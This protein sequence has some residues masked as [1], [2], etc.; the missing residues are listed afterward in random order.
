M[1]F[2]FAWAEKKQQDLRVILV[3]ASAAKQSTNSATGK[4]GLPRLPP[5]ARNI[6]GA[7]GQSP[8]KN[9]RIQK[10]RVDDVLRKFLIY[11]SHKNNLTIIS[12]SQ[13]KKYNN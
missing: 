4:T 8:R 10:N 3:I 2:Y 11:C 13:H 9:N 1:K 6:L 12:L 7:R 5:E